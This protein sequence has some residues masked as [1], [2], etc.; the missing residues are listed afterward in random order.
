MDV[1]KIG[2]GD[3]LVD[4]WQRF[5]LFF[6]F[7]RVSWPAFVLASIFGMCS[8]LC[9]QNI[10]SLY[11]T[12]KQKEE[13]KEEKHAFIVFRLWRVFDCAA[14]CRG[15]RGGQ[16]WWWRIIDSGKTERLRRWHELTRIHHHPKF[17][18]R[19]GT[20]LLRNVAAVALPSDLI[21]STSSRQRGPG[22]IVSPTVIRSLWEA[23]L[24]SALLVSLMCIFTLKIMCSMSELSSSMQQLISSS[25]RIVLK[26]F[27]YNQY[28]SKFIIKNCVFQ[29]QYILLLLFGCACFNHLR[30]QTI[31]K[32]TFLSE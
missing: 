13:R 12:M 11:L 30:K 29:D 9:R 23:Y 20:I 14:M 7:W 1:C 10:L 4:T 18:F 27:D 8:K 6:F 32:N 3:S 19:I 24:F 15:Q 22:L 31:R 2:K 25:T 5:S 28:W 16:W 26:L 21:S 17:I